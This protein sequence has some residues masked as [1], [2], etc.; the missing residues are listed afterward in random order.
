MAKKRKEIVVG[1]PVTVPGL[2]CY[3]GPGEGWYAIATVVEPD[4]IQARIHW[5]S[6]A[7]PELRWY[8][9]KLCKAGHLW[10]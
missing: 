10:A 8:E 5:Q 1:G 3:P 6:G 7:E 4:R 9:R 2:T